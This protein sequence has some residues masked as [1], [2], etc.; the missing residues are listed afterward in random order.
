[1]PSASRFF[2]QVQSFVAFVKGVFVGFP[3]ETA[4]LL[5]GAQVAVDEKLEKLP[6]GRRKPV[7]VAVLAGLA[8]LLLVLVEMA[9]QGRDAFEANVEM[10]VFHIPAGDL[11]PQMGLIPPEELFLPDEP[12]FIP[13]VILGRERRTEWTAEDAEPWWQ[14]PLADGEEQ[15]RAQIEGMVDEIMEGVP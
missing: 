13:G 2:A 9:L 5:D 3:K 1:M 7:I 12:D 10:R 4:K 14:N 6:S 8:V 15:W 11:P